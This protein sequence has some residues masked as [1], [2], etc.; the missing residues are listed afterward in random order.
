[1]TAAEKC[2]G[3][4]RGNNARGMF[5]DAGTADEMRLTKGTLDEITHES[6]SLHK[7]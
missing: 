5:Q 7:G 3:L 1:M 2:R 6:V 4:C